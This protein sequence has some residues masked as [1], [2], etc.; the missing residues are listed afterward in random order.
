[1]N[2]DAANPTLENKGGDVHYE[3]DFRSVYAT[4]IDKW[5]GLSFL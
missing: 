1:L 4:V 5:L 2:P 3:N